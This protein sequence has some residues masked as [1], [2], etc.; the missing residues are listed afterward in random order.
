MAAAGAAA[1]DESPGNIDTCQASDT[2][3]LAGEDAED[4]FERTSLLSAILAALG[5]ISM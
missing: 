4:L 3:E 1:G 2:V 5:L